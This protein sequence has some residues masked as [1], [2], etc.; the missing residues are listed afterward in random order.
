[1]CVRRPVR[2]L[3]HGLGDIVQVMPDGIGASQTSLQNGVVQNR[4][5]GRSTDVSPVQPRRRSATLV[6]AAAV[7]LLCVA[8]VPAP[9]AAASASASSPVLPLTQGPAGASGCW[10]ST[11]SSTT[12]RR[13]WSSPRKLSHSDLRAAPWTHPVF[14]RLREFFAAHLLLPQRPR[15]AEGEHRL[16][17][18]EQMRGV[19]LPQ[20]LSIAR[21]STGQPMSSSPVERRRRHGSPPCGKAGRGDAPGC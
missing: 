12:R 19:L 17:I 2:V 18:H 20:T 11:T 6:A 21:R 5:R 4:L 16:L 3:R 9:A 13:S 10:V 1:M 14:R 7:A 8:W 15:L